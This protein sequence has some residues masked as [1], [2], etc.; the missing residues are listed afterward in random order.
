M[1]LEANRLQKLAE[2]EEVYL[3]QQRYYRQSLIRGH[4]PSEHLYAWHPVQC[5]Y[6]NRLR[7]HYPLHQLPL[8]AFGERSLRLMIGKEQCPEE[9]VV[10]QVDCGYERS[11]D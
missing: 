11:W 1:E 3:H 4:E 9:V 5:L 2:S 7:T 6:R 8:L 10:V